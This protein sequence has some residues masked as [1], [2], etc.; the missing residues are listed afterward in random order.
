VNHKRTYKL[1]T[2]EMG[3]QL[4]NKTPKRRVRA[5]LREDR[6]PATRPNEVWAMDFLHDQLA[7]GTKI[8][9]LTVV[10]TFSW[11]S[12]VLDARLSYRGEDVVRTLLANTLIRVAIWQFGG[13]SSTHTSMQEAF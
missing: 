8:R 1:Y 12:P 11:F 6:H 10:D 13:L 9:V 4:R 3:L 5:K 7:T 2:R